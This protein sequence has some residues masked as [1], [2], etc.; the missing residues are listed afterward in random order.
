M[1]LRPLAAA[2]LVA[3]LASGARHPVIAVYRGTLPCGDCLGI[4]TELTIRAESP[5]RM[6]EAS[7]WLKQTHRGRRDGDA[8]YESGGALYVLRGSASDPDATVYELQE[9]RS[10]QSRYFL[11]SGDGLRM[12]DDRKAEIDS[13]L[14]HTL[15]RT[16]SAR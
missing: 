11:L 12:L 8:T 2:A 1:L 15:K 9:A 6:A 5:V 14:D 16:E 7:F 10:R 3:A 4:E 13:K